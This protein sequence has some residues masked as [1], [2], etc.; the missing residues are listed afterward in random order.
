MPRNG[1]DADVTWYEIN[2]CYVFHPMNAYEDGNKIVLDVCRMDDTMKPD[3]ISPPMLYRWVIDQDTGTVSETQ[4]DDRMADFVRVCDTVVGLK[5]RYGYAAAFAP[6]LP[7][8]EGF[9]KYDL[10]NNSSEFHDLN[11]GQGSEA[12]FVKDPDGEAEDDGWVLS[13]VHRPDENK[14]EVVIVD[15]RAF[16]KEPV[17]RIHLPVR[18]PAGF[19]GNW[20]PDGY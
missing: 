14:G 11:G 1:T 7:F 5:N 15:S 18:V 6:D 8:A 17:A 19:H 4:L 13:Y 3:S 10:D 12:V 20:V 16:D 2:P 9:L